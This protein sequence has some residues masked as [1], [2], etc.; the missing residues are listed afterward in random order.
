MRSN[1]KKVGKPTD[2]V[3]DYLLELGRVPLLTVEQE[4]QYARQVQHNSELLALRKALSDELGYEPED[5]E[6]SEAAGC[7]ADELQQLLHQGQ[8]AKNKMIEAN[9]RLV[10]SIAKKYQDC[11]VELQ[12]LIQEGNLGLNRA[13]EKFDPSKGFRFSTYATY[14]IKQAVTRAIADKSRVVRIPC[15]L[16]E[17]QMKVKKVTRSLGQQLGRQPSFDELALELNIHVDTLR[18]K[19]SYCRDAVSLDKPINGVEDTC[20][21][22][23]LVSSSSPVRYVQKLENQHVVEDLLS[24]LTQKERSVIEGR[25]GLNDGCEENLSIV[26]NKMNITRERA[27]QLHKTGI[28]RLKQSI[29]SAQIGVSIIS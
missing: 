8:R 6:W 1:S 18:L 3:G 20:L 15:H 9:L 4:I 28:E 22:D 23:L 2:S 19:L 25:Y 16:V 29:Q 13:V 24:N 21:G 7:D 5:L 10:V 12:D 11:G 27:R 14:W 26:G 17:F